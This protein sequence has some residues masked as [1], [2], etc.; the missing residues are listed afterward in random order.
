[1]LFPNNWGWRQGPCLVGPHLHKAISWSTYLHPLARPHVLFFCST[2]LLVLPSSCAVMQLLV[3]IMHDYAN[4]SSHILVAPFNSHGCIW[5]FFPCNTLRDCFPGSIL[6]C[7]VVFYFQWY[8]SFWCM[9][10]VDMLIA[11]HRSESKILLTSWCGV[12]AWFTDIWCFWDDICITT[13]E[14][15]CSKLAAWMATYAGWW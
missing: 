9:G 14:G 5:C 11:S 4:S 1:M 13:N 3:F 10:S 12:S 15:I 8:F 6:H 2:V 7:L